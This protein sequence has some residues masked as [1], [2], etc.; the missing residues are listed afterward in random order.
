MRTAVFTAFAAASGASAAF[1]QSVN[2]RVV[3]RTGQTVANAADSELDF[4]VQARC[5]GL[6]LSRFTF[7]IHMPGEAES[8]GVL[9]RG[10]ISNVDGT[11][12]SSITAG[13][14]V[15]RAGIARQ[16]SYL[17]TINPSFNGAINQS[18]GSFTNTP[19]QEIGLI[20]ASAQGTPTLGAPGID[21]DGDGNPDTWP[22]NGTG[23]TPA[24]GATAPVNPSAAL[25]YFANSSTQY[26]DVYR[27]R[28]SVTDLSSRNLHVQLDAILAQVFDN[29]IYDTGL[30]GAN[31]T[32][33][34]SPQTMTAL[35][36]QV[37]PAPAGAALLGLAGIVGA[38]RRR[39][40]A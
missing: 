19:D 15:G 8:R 11:Y 23:A 2:F 16:Y 27:F 9:A 32:G 39:R 36:I 35:D 1:G 17:A 25:A 12:D 14:S 7:N 5:I 31:T 33:Q 34:A 28:Y 40:I 21:T 20:A 37:V 18:A 24:P 13:A 6:S 38:R 26:V 4:A 22:G 30:W 3:E 29:W 10:N